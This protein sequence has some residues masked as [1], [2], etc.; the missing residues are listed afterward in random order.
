MSTR[1]RATSSSLSV[2][3]PSSVTRTELKRD[4][5]GRKVEGTVRDRDSEHAGLWQTTSTL[6]RAGQVEADAL[7]SL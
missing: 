5:R 4:G 2:I 3:G 7:E 1:A 6:H